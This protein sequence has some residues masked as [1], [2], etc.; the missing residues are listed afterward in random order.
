MNRQM[1]R[2]VRFEAPSLLPL[3]W[4]LTEARMDTPPRNLDLRGDVN[5]ELALKLIERMKTE[6]GRPLPFAGWKVES[7]RGISLR[8]MAGSN[9]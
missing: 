1:N 5:E 6:Y 4:V 3:K 7:P 9:A 8:E 2:T